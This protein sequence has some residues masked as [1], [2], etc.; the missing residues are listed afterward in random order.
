MDFIVVA[1]LREL[2]VKVSLG[3]FFR[4]ASQVQERLGGALDGPSEEESGNQKA[5]TLQ[6]G[7]E[8]AQHDAQTN[9]I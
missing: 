6:Q 7:D 1:E 4:G 5:Q 8:D 2:G 9:C 3:H